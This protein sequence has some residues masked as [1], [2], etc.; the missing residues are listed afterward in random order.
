MAVIEWASEAYQR[1]NPSA[2]LVQFEHGSATYVFDAAGL[3]VADRTVLIVGRPSAPLSERDASYQHG[4]PLADRSEGRPVDRGHFMPHSGGGL[5]GPNLFVQDRALNRGWSAEG[6]AYRRLEVRAAA[7]PNALLSVRPLYVDETDVPGFVELALV[8]ES[9]GSVTLAAR[10]FR[11]RYDVP[12]LRGENELDV[13]LQG[14]TNQQ[15]GDLGEETA[16]VLLEHLF[17]ATQVSMGHAQMSRDG[18]RQDLD[19][20]VLLGDTLVAVE[21]KTR[22]TG[23][24][25]GR[26]TRGGQLPAPRLG[27]SRTPGGPRQGSQDYVTARLSRVIDTETQDYVGIDVI[28]MVVDLNCMLAQLFDVSDTGQR[29]RRRTEP[30][31]CRH[32]V[33]IAWER[34]REHRG[35]L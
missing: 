11:N 21:V 3:D 12:L 4:Y 10:R 30:L 23:K 32:H 28:A 34:I 13:L 7:S 17:D 24:L 5:Y 14:A 29:T 27:R 31:E 16:M 25:A 1:A 20:V 8:E 33:E 15:L 22:Y 6:R 19:L 2:S 35:Y 18:G 26:L 9:A